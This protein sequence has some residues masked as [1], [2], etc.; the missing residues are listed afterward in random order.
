MLAR[1]LARLAYRLDKPLSIY[2]N[3]LTTRTWLCSAWCYLR[4]IDAAF[5]GQKACIETL[6]KC[7]QV[8]G[9][10]ELELSHLLRFSPG[11]YAM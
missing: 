10:Y 2:G 1:R 11:V 7:G 6:T 3:Y 5:G 8:P 9:F 4:L